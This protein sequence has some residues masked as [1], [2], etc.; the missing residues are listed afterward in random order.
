MSEKKMQVQAAGLAWYREAD[1]LAILAVMEDRDKLPATWRQW[2]QLAEQ[3]EARIQ[4]QGV[5]AVRVLIE[6]GPFL[7][8]CEAR[9]LHVDAQARMRF[10]NEAAYTEV[11]KQRR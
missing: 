7:D 9:G 5:L 2:H 11:M 8:W 1:Y 6:P 4:R 3:A 10:S